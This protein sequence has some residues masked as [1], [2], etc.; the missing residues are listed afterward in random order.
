MK[1]AVAIVVTVASLTALVAGLSGPATATTLKWGECPEGVP[2]QVACSKL[3]VPLDYAK[4][5]G[6]QITLTLSAI[7][8]LS[9]K[10]FMLVNPGGPGASGLGT[11]QMVSANLPE[12]VAEQY[13]VFSFDPR[14]VGLSSPVDCGDLSDLTPHPALPYRP[15]NAAQEQKRISLAQQVAARCGDKAKNLLPYIT[16]ENAARDMD[17]IRIALGREKIDYLGYS[18]GTKLGA[19]YATLFPQHTGRMILDSVVDPM[20]S[21]YRTAYEQ[22]PALQKR[23]QA[24][25]TWTAVRDSKYHLGKTRLAVANA[26]D[27]VHRKL[28]AKPAGGR[29]GSA[30]LDDLL[31]SSMYIDDSWDGIMQAVAD[32]RSGNPESLLAATDQLASQSVDVGQ[33]AYNCMD[34]GWPRNWRQWHNDTAASN[35]SAPLFAWLNTWYGAPC[36]FWPVGP[37]REIRIGS[38]EVPPIL[39]LQGKTDAAT[40]AIGALRMRQALNGS[41]LLVDGGGNHASYLFQKN[42]CIDKRAEQY[43][44]TGELPPDGMCPAPAPAE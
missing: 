32:Y 42:P 11:E 2:R 3:Q 7:G 12:A 1:K 34:R 40:P 16:T 4:P 17:R 13:A 9:A 24:L 37:A 39:L 21:T 28:S 36:A 15:A 8:S 23:A 44:L 27:E 43:L 5:A 19:T 6:Q 33:L 31:A 22:N 14:G 30:E 18:Y 41:R 35:A 29:A 25:F 10:H 38:V 26:F 20:V